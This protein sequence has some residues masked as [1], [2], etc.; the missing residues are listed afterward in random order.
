[1]KELIIFGTGVLVGASV[2]LLLAPESG[3]QLRADIRAKAEEE[4][5]KLQA[6]LEETKERMK[7][8]EADLKDS[9]EGSQ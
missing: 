6:S 8:L 3:E 4:L 5:P 2:A 9:M 7:V 1:M